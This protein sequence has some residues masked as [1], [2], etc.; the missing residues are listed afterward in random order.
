MYRS[1]G[2]AEVA[3]RFDQQSGHPVHRIG[4]GTQQHAAGGFFESGELREAVLKLARDLS[5]QA[6]R[7]SARY[8]RGR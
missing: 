5:R 3:M 2:S 7:T 1:A 8:R 6:R 4:L